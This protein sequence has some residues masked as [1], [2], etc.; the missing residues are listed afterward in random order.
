LPIV[1]GRL[2]VAARVVF[3]AIFFGAA[4][5]IYAQEEDKTYYIKDV[6]FEPAGR[7]KAGALE[8]ETGIKTGRE[9]HSKEELDSYLDDKKQ[10]LLNNRVFESAAVG[11]SEGEPEEDG[12][13]PI[14]V[15]VKT[16][17]SRNFIILPY[18]K[19]DNNGFEF[20]I[21][22]RDYNFLGSL[23]PLKA[24][25][26]GFYDDATSNF[27][28]NFALDSA[29]LFSAFGLN[30]NLN[31]AIS[32]AY[33]PVPHGSVPY[34]INNP[35]DPDLD[36]SGQDTVGLSVEIPFKNER[37]GIVTLGTGASFVINEEQ[38]F[39]DKSK[40]N[41]IFKDTKYLSQ[42]VFAKWKVL[43]FPFLDFYFI[44]VVKARFYEQLAGDP[45]SY[46]E[47][48]L[49]IFQNKINSEKIN[50]AGNF[51]EG[52]SISFD[53]D[54]YYNT[55]YSEVNPVLTFT[56]ASYSK[57]FNRF[58]LYTKMRGKQWFIN[59]FSAK[60]F[61]DPDRTLAGNMLRGVID[62]TIYADDILSFNFDFPIRVWDAMPSQWFKT[63]KL[64]YFNFEFFLS[65]FVDMAFVDG[66]SLDAETGEA[67]PLYFFSSGY[68]N[69][70]ATVRRYEP[71]GVFITS[72]F[73]AIFF[74]LTWRS[75][76]L[77]LSMGW[78]ITKSIRENRILGIKDAEIYIGLS[79]QY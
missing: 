55:K 38:D 17:D 8:R 46:R 12:R 79:L 35:A 77:R 72:G 36:E 59:D 27:E 1:D 22:L 16:E 9:F 30:W 75:L 18:P 39:F 41:N 13:V 58:G 32:A 50:W 26:G 65:P 51:K 69:S 19:Y 64:K 71:N 10:A 23:V 44:P 78:D 3:M 34:S 61:Y 74:P 21:K 31:F 24:E 43:L 60:H 57:F 48:P 53:G 52:Y 42:D 29:Y 40:T 28:L 11:Y 56:M 4:L 15:T 20:S 6:T 54:F 76:F 63:E 73:E 5:S 49:L 47:G 25:L 68:F 67:K 66:K 2:P 45:L 70:G 62:R 33:L 37:A 14:S 7:T